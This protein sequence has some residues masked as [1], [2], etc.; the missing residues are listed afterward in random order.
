[1]L[2]FLKK[3]S[4]AKTLSSYCST[5]SMPIMYASSTWPTTTMSAWARVVLCQATIHLNQSWGATAS[6]AMHLHSLRSNTT[7]EIVN[8]GE[9][10]GGYSSLLYGQS[11]PSTALA[12]I[13]K[14]GQNA[15]V[16]CA[17]DSRIKTGS[18][19]A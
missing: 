11:R 14:F 13:T 3:S 15:C 8:S 12:R 19:K 9:H 4:S 5:F 17:T 10:T 16:Y 2:N 1:M 7:W 6:S 18:L